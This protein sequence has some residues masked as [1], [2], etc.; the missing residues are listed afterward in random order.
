MSRVDRLHIRRL[1]R[2]APKAI[3]NYPNKRVDETV[4]GM[5]VQVI[6]ASQLEGLDNAKAEVWNIAAAI[7]WDSICRTSLH[8]QVEDESPKIEPNKRCDAQ[9]RKYDHFAPG[10]PACSGDYRHRRQWH[11]HCDPLYRT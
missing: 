8:G 6:E 2:A 9:R 11:A 7:R 5:K 3:A 10:R 1:T 4:R